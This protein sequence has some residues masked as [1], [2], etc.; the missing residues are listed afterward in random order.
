MTPPPALIDLIARQ[1]TRDAG[2]AW[3]VLL[4]CERDAERWAAQRL[5]N[6]LS[7]AGW[8]IRPRLEDDHR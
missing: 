6:V 3:D 7:T 5:V 8:E 2:R 4:P 1:R